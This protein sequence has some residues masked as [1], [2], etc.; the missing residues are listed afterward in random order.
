MRASRKLLLTGMLVAG[1]AGCAPK[2]AVRLP[3]GVGAPVADLAPVQALVDAACTEPAA[4]TA[5]LRLSGRIDGDRVRGTLQVGVSADSVRLEGIAPFG[6]PVFVLAGSPGRAVLL[7]PRDPAV[8]RGGSPGEL[9]DAVVGV[10]FGPADL[11]ALIAGCGV[12]GRRVLAA[13]TFPDGWTRA[14][15][16]ADRVLWLRAA[17]GAT[18]VVVAASDGAWEVTYTRTGGGWPTAIR[19]RRR[20]GG[21]GATDTTFTIDA[22]EA[23]AALPAA[24]LEVTIPDGTREVT[25]AELRTSREL[26]QR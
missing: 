9:L 21:Q 16:D 2:V 3:V 5:D 6:A 18:P 1:L 10:P 20:S 24:A 14:G 11:R 13:S 8:A 19:L 4:L 26:R 22:P 23:L 15:M 17:S 25:V 12:A 7:L